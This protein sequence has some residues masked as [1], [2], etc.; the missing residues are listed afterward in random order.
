MRK[1]LPLL[2]LGIE[3]SLATLSYADC[4]ASPQQLRSYEAYLQR[5]EASHDPDHAQLLNRVL[6]EMS[7]GEVD[8]VKRDIQAGLSPN[9]MVEISTNNSNPQR[10]ESESLL[11]VAVAMCQQQIA[12]DLVRWGASPNG[13]K[14]DD[15]GSP[16]STAA[17]FGEADVADFLIKHGADVNHP[18]IM[19]DTPLE[20]AIDQ[21]QAP[22]VLVLLKDGA[23][24]NRLT[25]IGTSGADVVSGL[26]AS[27][28]P[29]DRVIA[30]E[31]EQYLHR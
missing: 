12:E 13:G 30:K 8:A 26:K 15:R 24:P 23:D 3:F 4:P 9:A 5:Q 16:L 29:A 20:A 25:R 17:A 2:L 27:H 14:A 11:T 18:D 6:I 22:T 1:S 21:H 7:K 31:L 10:I 28:N 19:G